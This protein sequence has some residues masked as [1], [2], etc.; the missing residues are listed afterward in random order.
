MEEPIGLV[1]E[2]TEVAD[3]LILEMTF[4]PLSVLLIVFESRPD[5]LVQRGNHFLVV[6]LWGEDDIR[7]AVTKVGPR[8]NLWNCERYRACLRTQSLG[9]DITLTWKLFP[10]TLEST[11]RKRKTKGQFCL[12]NEF[13]SDGNEI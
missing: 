9:E 4:S 1:L 13:D 11:I 7:K 12:G 10:N 6:F 8:V 5:A 3:G 2:R